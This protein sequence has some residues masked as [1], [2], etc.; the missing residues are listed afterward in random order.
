[1]SGVSSGVCRHYEDAF[2]SNQTESVFLFHDGRILTS[3][4]DETGSMARFTA[5]DG[6]IGAAFS[7][8]AGTMAELSDG[9][10]VVVSAEPTG[11]RY[12]CN[13]V[14]TRFDSSGA[15][16]GDPVTL[17]DKPVP[18]Y[19]PSG[20]ITATP[21]GGY[22]VTWI[23]R[24]PDDSGHSDNVVRA[25]VVDPAGHL[26]HSNFIV[27]DD[28]FSEASPSSTVLANGDIVFCWQT[29]EL[30]HGQIRAAVF[31]A[32]GTVVTPSFVIGDGSTTVNSGAEIVALRDG[33]FAVAWHAAHPSGD[34]YA[35]TSLVAR[36][37]DVHGTAV[38]GQVV[39]S[40]A[41]NASDL[42][43]TALDSG[44]MAAV[45]DRGLSDGHVC[46]QLVDELGQTTGGEKD[47]DAAGFGYV[48]QIL[49]DGDGKVSVMFLGRPGYGSSGPVTVADF[50]V[51][52][53]L[54]L[55]AAASGGL[56]IGGEGNDTMFGG[57]GDDRLDGGPGFDRMIGGTGNDTYVVDDPRD[58]IVERGHEGTD[59][60]EASVS[61]D[62]AGM[63]VENLLLT[64]HDALQAI[65]NSLDNTITGNDAA[66]VIN[67][68]GGADTMIGGA[69]DDT[70]YVDNP[71]D[72]VIEHLNGGHDAVVS[73]VTFNA[74]G[75]DIETLTLSGTASVDL[76]GN[77][78]ANH[79]TGNGGANRLDGGVGA[80]VMAGGK[81]DDTYIVDNAGDTISE[82]KGEGT[83]VALS[84]VSYTLH[85]YI[86]NLTLTGSHAIDGTGN[87][88]ANTLVGNDR[89]NSLSGLGGND[90]IDAGAGNDIIIGGVGQDFMSGGT[91]ADRFVFSSGD[92]GGRVQSSADVITDF[93]HAQHDKIDL[94]AVDADVSKNGIQHFT[95]IGDAA[96]TGS[97][98]LR[99]DHVGSDLYLVGTLGMNASGDFKIHLD[100]LSSITAG[101]LVL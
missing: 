16:I 5:A 44:G 51:T 83:D 22:I 50:A 68:E 91:G 52:P 100:A 90:V 19:Y 64:G 2:G 36:V 41:P 89:A 21:G 77:E 40:D 30:G 62:L 63:Y 76:T 84:S 66:N 96:F 31:H 56:L 55:H 94:S 97:A 48:R 6:Q 80:D 75:Q 8:A 24:Y 49:D 69:G 34:S 82:L 74:S 7:L 9:G 98:E 37:F 10:F 46:F 58:T 92:F 32:D 45:W 99:V 59:T 25:Q 26:T 93:S 1:M 17:T 60:V 33:G 72:R 35:T 4:S 3:V 38:A 20:A 85:G 57:M 53:D 81:G 12:D 15:Q 43:V 54:V 47:L 78:L 13:L 11:T 14:A 39:L 28:G 42:H 79:L 27:T 29:D 67:G 101:D 70:Y 86:E 95:F 73:A 65:G 23:D 18:F 71:G 61:F 87:S 88:I